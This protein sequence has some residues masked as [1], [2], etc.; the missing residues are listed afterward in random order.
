MAKNL[1]DFDFVLSGVKGSA[2]IVVESGTARAVDDLAAD[3]ER[4]KDRKPLVVR[5]GTKLSGDVVIAGVVG[6]RPL[7][8]DLV[9]RGEI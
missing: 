6:Q 2:T 4:G 5:D 9:T 7:I 1:S 8:D 3:I